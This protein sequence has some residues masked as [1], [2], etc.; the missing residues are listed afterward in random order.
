MKLI[1]ALLVCVALIGFSGA[2]TATADEAVEA[3]DVSALEAEAD[4][5]QQMDADAL[6]AHTDADA[7]ADADEAEAATEATT[8]DTEEVAEEEEAEVEAETE[9]EGETERFRESA[10]ASA[11]A[12]EA[13]ALDGVLGLVDA[14]GSLQYEEESEDSEREDAEDVQ[15]TAE[16]HAQEAR[17]A[18]RSRMVRYNE[19]FAKEASV[20]AQ[21]AYWTTDPEQC[22][23]KLGHDTFELVHT[24][25]TTIFDGSALFAYTAKDDSK[26]RLVLAFHGDVTPSAL[27]KRLWKGKPIKYKQ[28]CKSCKT[29]KYYALVNGKLCPEMIASTRMLVKQHPDYE[30]VITGHGFGGALASMCGYEMEMARVFTH[31]N[32]RRF[33]SYG[34]PRV[35]NCHWARK[36]NQVFP[37]AIRVTHGDDPVVHIA[38][39]HVDPTT[40]RCIEIK[41]RKKR[42]WA[43]HNPTQVW[44]PHDMPAFNS[45]DSGDFQ[46]CQGRNWGEDEACR[47]RPLGFSMA[48]HNSYFGVNVATNCATALGSL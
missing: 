5:V 43:F 29:H 30:V 23:R 1:A 2:A 26:K 12:A 10:S 39:C 20:Y 19:N 4:A 13:L 36:F 46:V 3:L 35:G 28:L 24:V 40:Q 6:L 37:N 42:L 27:A 17:F 34:Q 21:A 44:Y 25:K 7:E 47:S 18:E 14:A 48:D 22:A 9:A 15:A 33:V 41:D 38:P 45:N 8:E 16:E 31:G 11:E 32:R